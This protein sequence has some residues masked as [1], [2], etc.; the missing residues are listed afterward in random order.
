MTDTHAAHCR[1]SAQRS[2]ASTVDRGK[3][4]FIVIVFKL[5][6]DISVLEGLKKSME[7]FIKGGVQTRSIFFLVKEGN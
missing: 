5:C 6:L 1:F 4:G 7:F 3:C 2:A